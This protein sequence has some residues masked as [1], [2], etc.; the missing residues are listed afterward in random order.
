[1]TQEQIIQWLN[2]HPGKKYTVPQLKH[3][4]GASSSIYSNLSK[5][6]FQIIKGI[7]K[8]IKVEICSFGGTEKAFRYW[9]EKKK[10]GDGDGGRE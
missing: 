8:D 4:L 1:M 2:A 6:R 7:E 5:I 10:K 9:Y 3:L